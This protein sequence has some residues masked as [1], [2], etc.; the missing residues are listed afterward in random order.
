ML[1]A[2]VQARPRICPL[3]RRTHA[4]EALSTRARKAGAA[5]QTREHHRGVPR[6]R[7]R[8]PVCYSSPAAAPATLP[9]LPIG[10]TPSAAHSTPAA[11]AEGG[12]PCP[13]QPPARPAC[14]PA[15]A[16]CATAAPMIHPGSRPALLRPRVP[17]AAARRR[18]RHWHLADIAA[19]LAFREE[20]SV[21]LS[22]LTP[23]RSAEPARAA[24]RRR[25][26]GGGA[27]VAEATSGG[28]GG[29]AG[30]RAGARRSRRRPPSRAQGAAPE[31]RPARC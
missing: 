23:P 12:S 15:C 21:L 16:A 6:N 31:V 26:R 9:P 3:S 24:Q 8:A 20:A 14:L 27:G 7:T 10:N 17:T 4:H 28:G 19:I 13:R 25:T 18:R 30:A 11:G 22:S 5:A 2:T 29:T 1:R